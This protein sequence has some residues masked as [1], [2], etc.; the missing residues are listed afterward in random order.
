[1]AYGAWQ[2]PECS[3]NPC[4]RAA[5]APTAGN[6]KTAADVISATV[7]FARVTQMKYPPYCSDAESN[8]SGGLPAHWII[9]NPIAVIEISIDGYAEKMLLCRVIKD[10]IDEI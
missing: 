3:E 7:F 1:M 9:V 6:K 4:F 10:I 5:Y 2:A 8:L